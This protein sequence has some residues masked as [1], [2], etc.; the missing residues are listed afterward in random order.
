MSEEGYLGRKTQNRENS[1]Y[2]EFGHTNAKELEVSTL[3]K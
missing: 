1:W 3:H 2:G